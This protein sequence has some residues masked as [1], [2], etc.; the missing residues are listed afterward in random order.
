MVI[1]YSY[2]KLKRGYHSLRSLR[3]VD[4]TLWQ[5]ADR[6]RIPWNINR[7]QGP[8]CVFAWMF[9]YSIL[10]CFDT[11]HIWTIWRLPQMHWNALKCIE[12][13]PPNHPMDSMKI[14]P[15]SRC[16]LPGPPPPNQRERPQRF[17]SPCRWAC[18]DSCPE[19]SHTIHRWG[20]ENQQFPIKS[21][22]NQ[23]RLV[24]LIGSLRENLQENPI[25]HR[26]VY[27]FL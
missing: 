5:G 20:I 4:G 25:F 2:V 16:C 18:P 7:I 21:P 13:L 15:V 27:G 17:F 6:K 8:G 1:F 11:F 26:K 12:M 14:R 10:K 23:W 3:L 22:I 9:I 19:N 24:Q